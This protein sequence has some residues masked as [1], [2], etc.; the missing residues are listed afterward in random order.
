[1]YAKMNTRAIFNIKFCV[2]YKKKR[3]T[4]MNKNAIISYRQTDSQTDR[5][6][7]RQTD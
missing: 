3:L 6:T 4:Q 5:Q 2:K 7:D 1:M